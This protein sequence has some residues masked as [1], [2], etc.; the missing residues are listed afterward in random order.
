MEGVIAKKEKREMVIQENIMGKLPIPTLLSK[1]AF[2]LVLSLL[3][4]AL[5]SIVDSIYVS[6]LGE[7]AL[8]AIS[9]CMTPQYLVMAVGTGIGV[10]VNAL[11]STRLGTKDREGVN[12]SA[13]NGIYVVWMSSI[14]FLVSGIVAIPPLFCMMTDVAVIQEMSTAYG[15]ILFIYAFA[16]FHQ[17]LM[18]RILV[19]AGKANGAMISMLVGS[20]INIILDPV[21]IWGYWGVP[22]MGIAGAAYATVFA[23]GCAAAV[24]IILNLCWNKEVKFRGSYL[25][26]ERDTLTD[27]IKIGIPVALSLSII[28]VL[29]FGVNGALLR[30]SAAAPAIYVIY[31]RLQSFILMPADGMRDAGISIIAYNYGAGNKRR[32]VETLKKSMQIYAVCAVLGIIV[33]WTIPQVLLSVFR[34]SDEM[35]QVGIPA[36]RIIGIAFPLTG[37]THIL[38]GFL[39]ALGHSDK[40]FIAAI[41][42]AVVLVGGAWLWSMT[43][44]VNLVWLAFPMTE[45]ILFILICW[46]SKKVYDQKVRIL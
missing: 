15:S 6:R 7:N 23:Q 21:L 18:E 22:A 37:S 40:S 44:N 10:G 28:S 17:I 16:S 9:L 33:F 30:L 20:V 41:V 11:L 4:Q 14:M 32:I 36:L 38:N 24:G 2:P 26:P 45:V 35:L 46:F 27:I 42:Q 1:M 39:Q 3:I 5:Y 43:G 8:T 12:R 29:A 13:G 25:K 34:A 31:I 19:A